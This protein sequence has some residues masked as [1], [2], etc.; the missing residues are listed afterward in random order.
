MIIEFPTLGLM[1][2]PYKGYTCWHL[3]KWGEERT[4]TSRKT[5]EDVVVPA[6]WQPIDCYPSSLERGLE[7]VLERAVRR[8]TACTELR[9]A[10]REVRAISDEIRR[11]AAVSGEAS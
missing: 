1:L 9:E 11:C 10:I 5:G 8:S 6:G 4:V 7:V 3:H 2:K